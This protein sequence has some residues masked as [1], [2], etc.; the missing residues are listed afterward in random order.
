MADQP[1]TTIFAA[2]NYDFFIFPAAAAIDYEI[3]V[4][5]SLLGRPLPNRCDIH[6][7]V[8]G[9][10]EHEGCGLCA[11]AALDQTDFSAITREVCNAH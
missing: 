8:W 3:P 7:V 5:R 4:P 11:D 6:N 10:G 9:D 2:G 1:Q